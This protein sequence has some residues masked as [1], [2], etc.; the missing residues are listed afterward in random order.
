MGLDGERLFSSVTLGLGF[1]ME[2]S[3]NLVEEGRHCG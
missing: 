1:L 3:G 2:G